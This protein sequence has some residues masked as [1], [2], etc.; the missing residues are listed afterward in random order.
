M[1]DDHLDDVS[2]LDLLRA[3]NPV[4]AV[5]GPWRDRPLNA[6]A[7]RG[8]NQLLHRTRTRRARRRVVLWAEAAAV[9]LAAVLALT[10]PDLGAGGAPPA[11]RPAPPP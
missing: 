6:V 3:A 1:T 10:V 5:E 9:A 8:L 11:P 2:D 4:S 7:E